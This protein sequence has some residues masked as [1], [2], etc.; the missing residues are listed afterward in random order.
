MDLMKKYQWFDYGFLLKMMKD[1]LKNSSQE[2]KTKG[3]NT[4]NMVVAAQMQEAVVIL[5]RLDANEYYKTSTNSQKA[6]QEDVDALMDL[7]KK[8]LL[9]WW[10]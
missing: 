3:H 1:W 2:F 5:E 8:N 9:S 10:D 4:D 6:K 7:L